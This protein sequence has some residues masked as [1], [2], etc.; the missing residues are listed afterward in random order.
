MSVSVNAPE[1]APA[2]Y[3]FP[4]LAAA[5]WARV[6]DQ[7]IAPPELPGSGLRYAANEMNLSLNLHV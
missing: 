7:P 6:G 5:D 2:I 3:T 4:G 1:L